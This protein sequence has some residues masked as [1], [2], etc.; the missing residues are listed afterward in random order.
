MESK[1]IKPR[2]DFGFGLSYTTF[3]YSDLRISA[4]GAGVAVV[5]TIKN[6]GAVPGTEIPQLY[7]SFPEGA[8]E[9]PKVLRGFDEVFLQPGESSSVTFSLNQRDI[10]SVS[11]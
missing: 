5:A 1:G 6:T 8:G 2:F 7:L 3:N 10:R 9:P 4:S 11:D